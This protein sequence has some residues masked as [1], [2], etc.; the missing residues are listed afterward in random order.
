MIGKKAAVN[1]YRNNLIRR[2]QSKA[3]LRSAPGRDRRQDVGNWQ[4]SRDRYLALAQAAASSGDAIEAENY[5]QHAEHYFRLMRE[6]MP[7]AQP[8]AVSS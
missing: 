8:A 2:A 6:R 7:A 4:R 3:P 5:Y 1:T